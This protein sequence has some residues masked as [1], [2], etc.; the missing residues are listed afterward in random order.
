[1]TRSEP[2]LRD[3]LTL[4]PERVSRMLRMTALVT[5]VVVVSM[6][7]RVPDAAVSAY[8]VFFVVNADA[9]T[10]VR[11]G[12]ALVVGVTIALAI[13]FVLF[14]LAT[15]EPAL[16][17]PLMVVMIFGGMYFL[18]T[19]P[20]GALGLGVGF[21]CSYALTYVDQVPAPE[22]LV[23]GLLWIWVV[24]AY[25]V[26]LIVL[27]DLAFGRRP[28]DIYREGIAA[29]LDA[30]AAVLDV[31]PGD[32]RRERARLERL[33]RGGVA[34]LAAYAKQGSPASAP[35]RAALLR[36]VELL[37]FLVRELPTELTRTPEAQPALRRAGEACR[38]AERALLR[39]D[40]ALLEPF[41][42]LAAERRR[43]GA[44]SPATLAVALPLVR[45]IET[46]VLGVHEVVSAPEVAGARPQRAAPP[47]VA[48]SKKTEAVR[49]ASKVTL[50]SMTAYLLY[51]G[52]SWFSIHTAMIT[53]FFVAQDSL[54]ATIHRLTLR[55][56][57]ALLG[58]G[59]GIAAIIL[60]LPRLESVGGLALL[61]AAVT[62]FAAWFATA[63][64]RISYAGWQ[65]AL[66]FYLTV[67]QGFSR[68]S[69][70]YV[71]R[72]RVIGILIGN[73]L[74]SVVFT[75]L[76]PVRIRPAMRQ[77]LSRSVESLA[78]MLRLPPEDRGE[79]EQ[80][81]A[82]FYSDFTAARQYAP[83]RRFEHGD[84]ELDGLVRAVAT[85]LIPIHA[86]V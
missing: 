57:G 36:Q 59:L 44:L 82:A 66:A 4:S 76:W 5:V 65:I 85:L 31:P 14:S 26:A 40:R 55:I 17:L 48:A 77:A 51:T 71:G 72:D 49:F 35:V 32:D 74:M 52:L 86:I 83:L 63:S 15:A 56:V 23:H 50:A 46:V 58:A 47:S 29:R 34:D 62:L 19:S 67:L 37:G 53:C 9:A 70:I 33:V 6:A 38:S 54:G 81:E 28:E 25:P 68:T 11:L 41:A 7:L 45:C 73:V 69:K 18:R 43:L 39:R 42:L 24:I 2:L 80:R 8:M 13:A 16:R 1:M 10:T 79:L 78:A 3:E 22:A 84:D 12:I 60:V 75:S 20:V 30:A 61:V 21:I 27:A 64:E